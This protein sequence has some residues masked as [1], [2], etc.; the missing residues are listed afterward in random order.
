MRTQEEISNRFAA[1]KSDD[2][3]GF[4]REAL[5]TFLDG[6][7]VEK[8]VHE[9]DA[10][11]SFSPK[12]WEGQFP[13]NQRTD[14]GV[15]REM[16]EYMAFAWD[17]VIH[18]RG[19]SASRSVEKMAEWCWLLGRDDLLDFAHD[20]KNYPQYGAPVLKKICEELGFPIPE[21]E[22]VQRMAKGEPRGADYPCGCG[23]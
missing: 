13:A 14:E 21:D 2:I 18:H 7:H 12:K 3:F 16:R 23:E 10:S 20:T 15:L 9:K 8:F 17:K 4:R 11:E 5:L 1:I 6:E 19:I 22:A